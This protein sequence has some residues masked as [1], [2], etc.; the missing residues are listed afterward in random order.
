ML[1]LEEKLKTICSTAKDFLNL[2]TISKDFEIYRNIIRKTKKN[3]EL[4]M[5]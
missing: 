4:K 1:T 2:N 3:V 5:E